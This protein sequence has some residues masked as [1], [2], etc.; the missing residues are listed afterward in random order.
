M[1]VFCLQSRLHPRKR[2]EAKEET[3]CTYKARLKYSSGDEVITILS[4]LLPHSVMEGSRSKR[5][6]Y[7]KAPPRRVNRRLLETPCA[8]SFSKVQ[9]YS[10]RIYHEDLH[11]FNLM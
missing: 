9:I 11:I 6:C 1:W 5:S 2:S 10:A 4:G 3:W 8:V 7:V